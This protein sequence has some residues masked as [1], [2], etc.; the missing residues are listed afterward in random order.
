[1]SSPGWIDMRLRNWAAE[2][3]VS[4]LGFVAVAADVADLDTDD[5]AS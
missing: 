5:W 4:A 3:I 2:G 1:M